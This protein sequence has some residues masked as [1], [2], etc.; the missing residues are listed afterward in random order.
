MDIVKIVNDECVWNL[1]KSWGMIS[2]KCRNWLS[3]HLV[4]AVLAH[5]KSSLFCSP[6]SVCSNSYTFQYPSRL[7]W[8]DMF[9]SHFDSFPL[10]TFVST[11]KC[12]EI[13]SFCSNRSRL[14]E[15]W[16]M[17]RLDFDCEKLCC[18]CE[19]YRSSFQGMYIFL[20]ESEK[21]FR[22]WDAFNYICGWRTIDD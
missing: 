12:K 11:S 3:R 1:A 2:Y 15:R 18:Y 7:S 20:I 4:S 16:W 21:A 19:A 5:E 13:L 17:T 10:L 6:T 8:I 9:I 14:K 22:S